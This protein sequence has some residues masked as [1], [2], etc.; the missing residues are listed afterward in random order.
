M[1]LDARW[2]LLIV[3][4]AGAAAVAWKSR[5]RRRRTVRDLEYRTDV[6]SWENEGGNLAPTPVAPTPP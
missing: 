5:R 6:R 4:V 3:V 2:V 1:D